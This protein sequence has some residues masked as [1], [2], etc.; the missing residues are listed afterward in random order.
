MTKYT[1]EQLEQVGGKLWEK[2]NMRRVYFNNLAEWYGLT[3]KHYN[4]GNISYAEVDG[5][6]ISNSSARELSYNLSWG[7]VWYDFTDGKFH[8]KGMSEKMATKIID[9]I[10]E[11]IQ[12]EA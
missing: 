8:Y 1:V 10:T 11:K 4:T 2:G 12:A 6:R 9:R 3:T 5:E 7:K